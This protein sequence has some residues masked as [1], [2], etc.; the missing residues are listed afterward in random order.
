MKRRICTVLASGLLILSLS[1]C[2]ENQIPD[3]TDEQMQLLGEY[4]AITLMK[5]DASRRSRLVEL[6]IVEEFYRVPEETTE[7]EIQEPA[8]MDPVDETPVVDISGGEAGSSG[9][10]ATIEQVLGLP[11][12]ISILYMGEELHKSYPEDESAYF[13][14]TATE[15]RQLLILNFS[16]INAAAQDQTV[17]I[18]SLTPA[19]QIV[20][21]GN[22]TRTALPTI[23][24]NDMTAF[25][26]TIPS[27]GS[28]PVILVV[29]VDNA[30]AN[31]ITSLDLKLKNDSTTYTIQLTQ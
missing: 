3:M 13:A 29:E 11:E 14:L 12:E 2:G 7:P 30:T 9:L 21:N 4:T 15:G 20:V 25:N 26:G 22:Y 28:S 6:S 31:N 24:E 18:L 19:F 27:M 5:Y 10:S 23:L 16:I 8:G 17:N 1:G